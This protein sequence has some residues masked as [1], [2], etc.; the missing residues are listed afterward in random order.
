M[1]KCST[2]SHFRYPS[3]T[4][5][6]TPIRN[7][8]SLLALRG[9]TLPLTHNR[10]FAILHPI[11]SNLLSLHPNIPSQRGIWVFPSCFQAYPAA[12]A[13]SCITL[14][15]TEGGHATLRDRL[16]IQYVV[17]ARAICP[18]HSLRTTALS[19]PNPGDRTSVW[20]D[21]SDWRCP[22]LVRIAEIED[23]KPYSSTDS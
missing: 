20:Q 13:S 23:T 8:F 3:M 16:R 12:A 18:Y 1:A 6:P 9:S 11:K 14:I 19:Q 17:P 2:G 5:F 4:R 21:P 15:M 22:H 10:A 7:V